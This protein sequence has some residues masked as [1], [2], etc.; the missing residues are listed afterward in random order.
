MLRKISLK[1]G[2]AICG[3]LKCFG[4]GVLMGGKKSI[5]TVV[6]IGGLLLMHCSLFF[7]FNYIAL[8]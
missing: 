1:L 7:V 4:F 5:I 6:S 3:L 8:T 2:H